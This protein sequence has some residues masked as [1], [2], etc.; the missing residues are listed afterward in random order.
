M[1]LWKLKR[2]DKDL[3]ESKIKKDREGK[4]SSPP[5]ISSVEPTGT[6]AGIAYSAI[7]V[8]APSGSVAARTGDPARAALSPC[9]VGYSASAVAGLAGSAAVADAA[10]AGSVARGAQIAAR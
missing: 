8:F 5:L 1:G 4:I 2:R 9:V 10:V 3:E 7:A 6:A